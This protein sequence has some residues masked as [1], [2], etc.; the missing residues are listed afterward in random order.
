[1]KTD[2]S[3]PLP[4][5]QVSFASKLKEFREL[6]LQNA[7]LDTIGQLEVSNIDVELS[8]FVSNENLKKL[9]SKG[10][11]GEL[12]FAVPAVL[13]ANPR[14][15]GY[16]RLLLG[17]SQK[18]FY[19]SGFGVMSLKSMETAGKLN[20]KA[21]ISIEELCQ[22]L[23]GAASHLVSG[24]SSS[25]LNIEL[26]DDLTLL[27]VGPQMRG[28]VNNKLGQKGIV[29]VF[30]VI[31]EILSHAI[32]SSTR[33]AIEIKNS[34]GRDV[35]V[36]FASDPDIVIRETMADGAVRKILAIEVKS[37]TDISNIHNRIGEAEKSHQKAKNEGYRECW[38]VVNVAKLDIAKAK[39]ESPTTNTFYSLKDLMHKKGASYEEFKQNIIAMV[40]IPSAQ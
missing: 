12:V 27:T 11:R 33:E 21:K 22:A 32:V 10:L 28:G 40:G 15:L 30:A 25:D 34:G 4:E 17:Y 6:W 26:L 2:L 29:D 16:Y 37:G 7:L 5:L 35:W 9:A 3:F 8:K 39:T 24:L 36:K 38:T 1:M 31:Q 19:G 14:L 18:E 13:R 20:S 23:C